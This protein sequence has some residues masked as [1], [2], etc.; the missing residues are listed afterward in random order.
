MFEHHTSVVTGVAVGP[1][2]RSVSVSLDGAILIFHLKTGN[3]LK[4]LKWDR[5]S[6][7]SVSINNSGTRIAVGSFGE[8]GLWDIQRGRLVSNVAGH[9]KNISR[10]EYVASTNSKGQ[11][12]EN[13]MSMSSNGELKIWNTED[14]DL[15]HSASGSIGKNAEVKVAGNKA[16]MGSRDSP[17]LKVW[18]LNFDPEQTTAPLEGGIYDPIAISADGKYVVTVHS[19]NTDLVLYDVSKG[20]ELHQIP[21]HDDKITCL[22]MLSVNEHVISGSRDGVVKMWH[23]NGEVLEKVHSTSF[24]KEIKGIAA[25]PRSLMAV[26]FHKDNVIRLRHMNNKDV[27]EAHIDIQD[28]NLTQV[29][30]G[31][32]QIIYGTDIGKIYVWSYENLDNPVVILEE[33]LKAISHLTVRD[34]YLAS[35]GDEEKTVIIWNCKSGKKLGDMYT[36]EEKLMALTWSNDMH[37]LIVGFETCHVHIYDVIA[38]TKLTSLNVY[39]PVSAIVANSDII[40]ISTTGGYLGVYKLVVSEAFD[41]SIYSDSLE[42]RYSVS[43]LQAS[44]A[45]LPNSGERRRS[46]TCTLI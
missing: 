13:L 29:I 23:R 35:V 5:H 27:D 21:A 22:T 4:K 15:S 6:L 9:R 2:D 46:T 10:I 17:F 26:I 8:I 11:G 7:Y 18:S 33:H 12:T 44:R 45:A 32:D 38:Q 40:S 20:V 14:D 3:I 37:H 19:N 28:S 31:D 43:S 39:S 30:M 25:H 24:E 42:S 16:A 41:P 36:G 34:K 1:D